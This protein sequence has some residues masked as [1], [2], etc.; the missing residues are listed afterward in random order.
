MLQNDYKSVLDGDEERPTEY[1]KKYIKPVIIQ[2]FDLET[3][4]GSVIP[5]GVDPLELDPW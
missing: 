5:S 1:R 4:A 3:R 2:E